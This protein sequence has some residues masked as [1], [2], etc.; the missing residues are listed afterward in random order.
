MATFRWRIRTFFRVFLSLVTATFVVVSCLGSFAPKIPV[1]FTIYVSVM[2]VVAKKVNS[3][4]VS[5]IYFCFVFLLCLLFPQLKCQTICKTSSTLLHR[6]KTWRRYRMCHWNVVVFQNLNE[7]SVC[8]I[9][10]N[11]PR[12]LF[13]ALALGP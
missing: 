7:Q 10:F 9:A 3:I 13:S 5:C 4:L 8:E 2:F 1:N 12:E 6:K 11:P